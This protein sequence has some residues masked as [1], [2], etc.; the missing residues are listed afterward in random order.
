MADTIIT[1]SG[2]PSTRLGYPLY[3]REHICKWNDKKYI[4]I[5]AQHYQNVRFVAYIFWKND[6]PTERAMG[7]ETLYS[8]GLTKIR[9]RKYDDESCFS[10]FH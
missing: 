7:N 1:S 9:R 4:S 8:D 6:R 3:D 5:N 10:S 2:V